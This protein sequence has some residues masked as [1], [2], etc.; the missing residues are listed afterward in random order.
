MTICILDDENLNLSQLF[1]ENTG[2]CAAILEQTVFYRVLEPSSSL[3][4]LLL[5]NLITEMLNLVL[6]CYNQWSW[7]VVTKK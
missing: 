3:Y 4:C 1:F 2:K 5:V 7:P 6:C